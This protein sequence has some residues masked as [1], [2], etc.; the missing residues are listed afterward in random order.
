MKLKTEYY[1][2]NKEWRTINIINVIK[3]WINL[4]YFKLFFA[5]C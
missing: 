3:A 2:E 4:I 1:R 5:R